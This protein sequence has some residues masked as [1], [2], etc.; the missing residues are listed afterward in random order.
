MKAQDKLKGKIRLSKILSHSGVCS[1]R[2][3]ED[4]IKN[5]HVSVNGSVFK[6]FVLDKKKI[7]TIYVNN[8]KIKKQE[9]RLWCLNKPVGYVSS[10]REQKNQI[11]LFRLLPSKIPRVVSIGRLDIKSEGLMILTNN[12]SVSD[13][14]EKPINNIY[15]VYI[16][17]VIGKITENFLTSV[18]KKLVIDGIIYRHFKLDILNSKKNKHK[19]KI[20]IF[21]GKNRE[22]R[23]IMNY[24]KFKVERLKRVEYGPLKLGELEIG[25]ILEI[26]EEK[27]KII[28]KKFGIS[29]E[30]Y[31]W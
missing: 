2:E 1:R 27:V 9:T 21:E 15:R 25:K 6:N 4:L 16:V 24:F 22:I 10:N 28:L 31:F 29:D 12:P 13:F 11:S 19:F 5:G 14:F 20:K 23:K 30:N 17:Y 18:K 8:K 3:A 26:K 7:E